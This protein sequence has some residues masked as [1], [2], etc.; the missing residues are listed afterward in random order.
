MFDVINGKGNID[1]HFSSV[2]EYILVNLLKVFKLMYNPGMFISFRKCNLWIVNSTCVVLVQIFN[3]TT[4][5]PQFLHSDVLFIRKLFLI[6][7]LIIKSRNISKLIIILPLFKFLFE[8]LW[9]YL[10]QC[11]C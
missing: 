8:L 5:K 3:S 1:R 6:I 7:V 9:L 10:G 4:R 11:I 2:Q